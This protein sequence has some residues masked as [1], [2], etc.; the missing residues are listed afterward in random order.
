M[1]PKTEEVLTFKMLFSLLLMVH[2]FY[3]DCSL[4]LMSCETDHMTAEPDE[5]GIDPGP[6]HK[7]GN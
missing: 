6:G 3:V 5:R 7:A 2:N 4:Y 1:M